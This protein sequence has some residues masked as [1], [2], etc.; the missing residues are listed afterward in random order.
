VPHDR[1]LT[2]SVLIEELQGTG[3]ALRPVIRK[4]VLADTRVSRLRKG[5]SHLRKT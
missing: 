2:W 5:V 1:D 4:Q 3:Q